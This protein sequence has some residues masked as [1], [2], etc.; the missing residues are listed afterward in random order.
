MSVLAQENQ[1]IVHVLQDRP[2]GEA[3]RAKDIAAALGLDTSVPAKVEGVR[4]KAKRLGERGWLLQEPR[5]AVG[6]DLLGRDAF[7]RN[8]SFVRGAGAM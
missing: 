2:G 4:S 3:M 1:R 8:R 6:V 5:P 7:E